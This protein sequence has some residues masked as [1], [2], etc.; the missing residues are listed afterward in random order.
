M[1]EKYASLIDRIKATFIDSLVIVGM[2]FAATE[3]LTFFENVPDLVKMFLFV[4]I[5]FL[6]EPI[7]VSLYGNSIGHSY[8]GLCVRKEKD[9]AKKISFPAAILRFLCKAFLGWLSL[10]TVTGSSKKQA[11]HDVLVSSIILK[12]K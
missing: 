8:M 6:Y 3:I 1:E 2:L 11:I 5:F 7:F 4:F 9:R 12:E 10:L